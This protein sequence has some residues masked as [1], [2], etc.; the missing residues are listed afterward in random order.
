MFQWAYSTQWKDRN[1]QQR[2]ELYEAEALMAAEYAYPNGYTLMERKV[3]DW[4]TPVNKAPLNKN[5]IRL[6]VFL[7]AEGAE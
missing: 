1:N 7:F 2:T 3:L 5:K 4:V 6:T